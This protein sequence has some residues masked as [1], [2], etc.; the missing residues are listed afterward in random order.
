MC[1]M[2]TDEPGSAHLLLVP[3]LL[4]VQRRHDVAVGHLHHEVQLPIYDSLLGLTVQQD[5]DS[6]WLAVPEAIV[7]T[8]KGSK[9]K[10][11]ACRMQAAA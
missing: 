5:L 8:A 4:A 9:A 11:H 10:K 7:D 3:H 2:G 6:H 1:N